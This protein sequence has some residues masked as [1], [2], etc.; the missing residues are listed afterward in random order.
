MCTFYSA[1]RDV[2]SGSWLLGQSRFLPSFV[3]QPAL[4]CCRTSARQ[5]QI[6]LGAFQHLDRRFN[7]DADDERVLRRSHIERD[8]L[9]HLG[10]ERGIVA[11]V[12]GLA[13]GKVDLLR[14]EKASDLLDVDITERGGD[15]RSAPAGMAV[16]RLEVEHT[17]DTPR[18]L[19]R[20]LRQRGPA[21]RLIETY[22]TAPSIAH[23]PLRRHAHSAADTP[24]GL[25]LP[26]TSIPF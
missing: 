22:E 9:G 14:R 24:A 6:A 19:G 13:G 17:Q 2:R 15:Q 20:V 5:L 12:P 11:L 7:V 18:R 23:A 1:I 10:S 16:G 4:S 3:V 25:A 8:H 26:P 21:A